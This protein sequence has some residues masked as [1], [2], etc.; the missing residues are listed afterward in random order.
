MR[1]DLAARPRRRPRP[2][3][4]DIGIGEQRLALQVAELDDV[5]GDDR[6]LLPTPAAAR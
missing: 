1:I 2:W 3:R 6:Q 4:A 5:M